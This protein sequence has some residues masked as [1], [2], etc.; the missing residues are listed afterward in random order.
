SDKPLPYD[1]GR[2]LAYTEWNEGILP[3]PW[4]DNGIELDGVHFFGGNQ[5][6]Y[7]VYAIGGPR[8]NADGF[9]FDYT[10]SRSGERYYI[11]NNSQPSVGGRL[12]MT[13]RLGER[14]NLAVGASGMAGRYDP[15]ARLDFEIGG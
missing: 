4:V 11:D 9:D 15:D 7:A 8:G 10:L 3:A 13:M 6:D 12:A 14:S 2:M 5:L 1:M